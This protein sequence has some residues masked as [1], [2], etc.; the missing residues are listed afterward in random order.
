MNTVIDFALVA[1]RAK[2]GKRCMLTLEDGR[3]ITGKVLRGLDFDGTWFLLRARDT[4]HLPLRYAP[5]LKLAPKPLNR[6][7]GER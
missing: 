5:K 4:W 3:T 2:I 1:Y 7:Q 6:K